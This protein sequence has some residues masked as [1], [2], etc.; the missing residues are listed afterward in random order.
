MAKTYTLGYDEQYKQAMASYLKKD[1]IDAAAQ[2]EKMLIQYPNNALLHNDLA[3]TYNHLGRYEDAIVQAREILHRIGDK[4]Q[5]AAAQY[6][7][8]FAYEMLGD[9][10][11]ALAN[12]KLSVANGNITVNKDVDRINNIYSDKTAAFFNAAKNIK[13]QPKDNLIKGKLLSKSDKNLD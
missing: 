2:F 12:Y 10:K 3:A 13:K 8:G 1:Y 9:F 5:Y 6:N 4:S 11:K 7:A